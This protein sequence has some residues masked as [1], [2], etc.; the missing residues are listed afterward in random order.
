MQK[1]FEKLC[2]FM[3]KK[4]SKLVHKF[5]QKVQHTVMQNIS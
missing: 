1:V 3:Q 5:M 4:P 2:I